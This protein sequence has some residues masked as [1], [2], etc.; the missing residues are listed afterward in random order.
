[1]TFFGPSLPGKT[2]EYVYRVKARKHVSEF[3]DRLIGSLQNARGGRIRKE[4][5]ELRVVMGGWQEEGG[6]GGGVILIIV[7]LIVEEE[8][9]D[10]QTTSRSTSSPPLF[11]RLTF[12]SPHLPSS[13]G[14]FLSSPPPPPTPPHT[15]WSR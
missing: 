4:V 10:K 12:L 15:S 2:R 7:V 3:Q 9:G 8:V 13:P 14:S 6:G 1:V 11:P 5:S